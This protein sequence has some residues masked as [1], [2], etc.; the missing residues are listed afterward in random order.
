MTMK[1]TKYR[2]YHAPDGCTPSFCGE[3]GTRSAAE[4]AAKRQPVGLPQD[5]W[6]TAR[7]AGHVYGMTAP[8]T[9]GVEADEPIGWYGKEG[10]HC[11]VA[12]AYP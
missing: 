10:W 8:D 5:L 11:V 4:R 3:Y 2:V 1:T 7:A 6:E 12:V 9:G